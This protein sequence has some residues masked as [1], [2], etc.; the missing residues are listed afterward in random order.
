M[1]QIDGEKLPLEEVLRNDLDHAG[2]KL[3]D[4]VYTDA[5]GKKHLVLS[6]LA[7]ADKGIV[8]DK[9]VEAVV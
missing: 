9:T 8:Y 6:E 5:E 7:D 4:L 2:N 3:M 1:I